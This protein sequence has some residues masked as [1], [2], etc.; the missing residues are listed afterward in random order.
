MNTW[1]CRVPG[2]SKL[3]EPVDKLRRVEPRRTNNPCAADHRR[4]GYA[5]QSGRM[6]Q[7]H[8]VQAE[9]LLGEPEKHLIVFGLVEDL[10]LSQW[11]K[12]WRRRGSG[13][14]K[15]QRLVLCLRETALLIPQSLSTCEL[16]NTGCSI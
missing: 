10:V 6:E 16:K 3:V 4:E 7:R 2:R 1:H 12:L 15:Q 13:S 8:H 11:N 5:N 14:V 9:I